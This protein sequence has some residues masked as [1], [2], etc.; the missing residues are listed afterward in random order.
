MGAL[1]GNHQEIR[2][3]CVGAMSLISPRAAAPEDGCPPL[4]FFLQT[5]LE[6]VA[7]AQADLQRYCTLKLHLIHSP[8]PLQSFALGF[9]S[10]RA[11]CMYQLGL[12]HTLIQHASLKSKLL[13]FL[14][15]FKI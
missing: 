2:V 3:C 4:T 10:F 5:L 11:K 9:L 1:R 15:L 13:L 12:H 6:V 7:S 14:Y 8:G